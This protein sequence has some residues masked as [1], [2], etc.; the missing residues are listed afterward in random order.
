MSRS[1]RTEPPSNFEVESREVIVRLRGAL[2]DMIASAPGERAI[3]RASDFQRNFNLTTTLAWR[4]HRFATADDPFV[5]A[6]SIPGRTAINL[7]LDSAGKV[8]VPQEKIEELSEAFDQFE[9]LVQTHAGNRKAF[10]AMVLGF[11]SAAN[12]IVD[13]NHRKQAFHANSHIWGVQV[14]TRLRTFIIRQADDHLVDV[15]SIQGAVGLCR[16][17]GTMPYELARNRHRYVCTD[18]PREGASLNLEMHG[19][20]IDTAV[21]PEMNGP[22]LLREFSSNP[23]LAIRN[24]IDPDGTMMTELVPSALGRQGRASGMVANIFPRSTPRFEVDEPEKFVS[25]GYLTSPTEVMLTDIL[26]AD[27]AHGPR[28]PR[29]RGY[30]L[31]NF[32]GGRRRPEH[33]VGEPDPSEILDRPAVIE[34]GRGPSVLATPE[35]PRY[36]EMFK[37]VCSNL[38]WDCNSFHVFRCRVEYPVIPSLV[39]VEYDLPREP[40]A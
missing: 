8:N 17:H 36:P 35:V 12:P 14:A 34:L 13:L 37:H 40:K 3:H 4:I 26:I 31:C 28:I 6:E 21:H 10:N 15:A 38:G 1:D 19:N 29:P 25:A 24:V 39:V 22:A 11:A 16:L 23:D 5:E 7:L 18:K 20:P 32:D 27:G 2:A 9:S 30:V 33:E